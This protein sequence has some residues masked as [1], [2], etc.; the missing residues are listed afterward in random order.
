MNKKTKSLLVFCVLIAATAA[1]VA[2]TVSPVDA[3]PINCKIVQC[4]APDCN[5]NEHLQV[6]AGQCC[7]ICVPN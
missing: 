4:P 1:L 7:P 5:P 2:L 3:R 6:P